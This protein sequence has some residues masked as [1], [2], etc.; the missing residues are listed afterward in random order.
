MRIH[1]A[2]YPNHDTKMYVQFAMEPYQ[3]GKL[4]KRVQLDI[5][6]KK[7]IDEDSSVHSPHVMTWPN[8]ANSKMTSLQLTLRNKTVLNREYPGD[9]GWFK[10]VNQS[11]ES[12]VSKKQTLLNLSVNEVPV[13]YYLYTDGQVNPFLSLNLKHFNLPDKIG[14]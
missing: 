10:L 14:E 7:I 13:K 8:T 1:H 12:M 9:W 3:F 6:D 11:F 2:F 4:V 5:N